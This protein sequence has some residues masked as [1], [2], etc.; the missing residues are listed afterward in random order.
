MNPLCVI[1]IYT[2]RDI[3]AD[4]LHTAWGRAKA[5]NAYYCRIFQG[6][7]EGEF[8]L[9]LLGPKGEHIYTIGAIPHES[10]DEGKVYYSY[11]S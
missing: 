10:E 1:E 8:L 9:I 6:Y 5:F 7:D 2:S 11:H 3:P 4:V